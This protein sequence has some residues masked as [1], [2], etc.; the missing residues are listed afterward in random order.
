MSESGSFATLLFFSRS[1]AAGFHLDELQAEAASAFGWFNNSQLASICDKRE[2][3]LLQ[4]AAK[5]PIGGEEET[6]KVLQ[7]VWGRNSKY[8]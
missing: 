3:K 4:A 7:T 2:R 1:G 8:S 5:S 6:Y